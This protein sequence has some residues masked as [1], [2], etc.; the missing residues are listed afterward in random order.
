M[1]P[2]SDTGISSISRVFDVNAPI[3]HTWQVRPPAHWPCSMGD[4]RGHIFGTG[5]TLKNPSTTVGEECDG[6]HASCGPDEHESQIRASGKCSLD[7]P[8][9]P[10]GTAL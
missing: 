9:I 3:Y 10:P 6:A 5:S 7:F 4:V 1:I 8:T 2:F